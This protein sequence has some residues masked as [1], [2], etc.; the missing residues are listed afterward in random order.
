MAITFRK[1]S[2]RYALGSCLE[3]VLW[4]HIDWALIKGEEWQA[5]SKCLYSVVYGMCCVEYR[6]GISRVIRA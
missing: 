1:I 3:L 2:P 4:D 6:E 5:G